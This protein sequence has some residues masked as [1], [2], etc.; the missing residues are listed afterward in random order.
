MILRPQGIGQFEFVVLASLRASQ[1][2]RGCRARVDGLHTV[3]VMAQLE[4]AG[5]TVVALPRAVA[6]IG[7][8]EEDLV[9]PA[10]PV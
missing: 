6:V 3:A 9:G 4:I 7:T 10:T 5:G 8:P 2:T 1:L